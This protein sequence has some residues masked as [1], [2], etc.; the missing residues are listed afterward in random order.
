MNQLKDS[1]SSLKDSLLSVIVPVFN[2]EKNIIENL[3]LLID[4]VE[5]TFPHFEIIVVSDGSTDQTNWK[6]F[7]FK[8]PKLQ[9]HI[10]EQ[11]KGKGHAVRSGFRRAKGDFILFIDGGMELHPREIK[12]FVGLMDLYQAD[13]VIGSKRHPQSEVYYPW[14][15]KLLSWVFQKCVHQLFHVDVTDTQVGIKLFR[16]QVIEDVLPLLR[17]DRYGF[18]LEI[19]SLA[20]L[21]GHRRILE[22][23]IRMDYFSR[24]NRNPFTDIPHVLR[25]G[26][27]LLVDTWRLYMRLQHVRRD[28]LQERP[29]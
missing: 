17:I 29:Q 20:T 19:L 23:P 11:N 18:D 8:H 7:S 12:I 5:S 26:L 25:V 21:K 24:Q 14:Y 10:V 1:Q 9:L 4:E 27:S 15:R 2:E 3:D 13:I 22:A 16:R 28:I 6:V